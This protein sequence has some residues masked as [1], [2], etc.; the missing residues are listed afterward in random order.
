MHRRAASAG[1]RH[2]LR[3][4]PTRNPACASRSLV[5]REVGCDCLH[6]AGGGSAVLLRDARSVARDAAKRLCI[7][8]KPRDRIAQIL[9]VLDNKRTFASIERGI[10]LTEIADMRPM[11]N[12]AIQFCRL[13][14]VLAAFPRE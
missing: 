2:A 9:P 4:V 6:H 11:Q 5:V 1:A 12:G 10:D 8:E 13:D 7:R 14:G 3:V